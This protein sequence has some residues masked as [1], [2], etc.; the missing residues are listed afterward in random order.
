MFDKI[1]VLMSQLFEIVVNTIFERKQALLANCTCNC[2]VFYYS[3]GPLNPYEMIKNIGKCGLK[4]RW[5]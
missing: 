2:I 1:E 5:L 3:I 4:N